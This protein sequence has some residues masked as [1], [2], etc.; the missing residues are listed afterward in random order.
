M[1]PSAGLGKLV[2]IE[3]DVNTPDEM[4]EY[5]FMKST[6]GSTIKNITNELKKEYEQKSE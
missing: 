6:N 5:L 1:V 3:D 2:T 4:F